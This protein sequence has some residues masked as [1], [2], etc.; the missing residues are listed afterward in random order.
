MLEL[1]SKFESEVLAGI[2]AGWLPWIEIVAGICLI[3]GVFTPIASLISAGLVAAFIFHN[4]WMIANGFAYTPCSCLG[5][6]EQFIQ[7]RLPTIGSLYIDIG[8]LVLVLLIYFGY[9]GNFFNWRPW[10]LKKKN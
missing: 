5:V 2:I 3:A 8:M 9:Q 6:L 10:Y 1:T 7:G 4:A